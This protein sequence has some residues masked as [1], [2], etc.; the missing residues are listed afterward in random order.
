MSAN[1][2]Q[3][4]AV[5]AVFAVLAVL[6]ASCGGRTVESAAPSEFKPQTVM[7][8]PLDSADGLEVIVQD[9]YFPANL[10]L[11]RHYHPGEEYIYV[12]E[13][14]V[15]HVQEGED[16]RV[17]RAGEALSIGVG[18]VHAAKTGDEPARAVIFRVH[19]R[20]EPERIVVE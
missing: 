7:R 19:R 16:D 13:G 2:L 8:A 15:T 17:Y 4:L 20:G 11:P 14:E 5:F 3:I 1:R 9:V 18:K 10:E 6:A 12:I